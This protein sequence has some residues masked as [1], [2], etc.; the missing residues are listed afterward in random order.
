MNS[1]EFGLLG[2]SGWSVTNHFIYYIVRYYNAWIESFPDPNYT[3]DMDYLDDSDSA[4]SSDSASFDEDESDDDD[5]IDDSLMIDFQS[6]TDSN[7]KTEPGSDIEEEVFEFSAGFSSNDFSN[8][9]L[10]IGTQQMEANV[11][12]ISPRRFRR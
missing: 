1:S 2:Q 10:L 7:S 11:M 6:E 12:D 3:T 8:E 5:D 4:S 9:H